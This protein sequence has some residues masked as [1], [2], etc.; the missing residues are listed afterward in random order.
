MTPSVAEITCMMLAN[1]AS[2]MQ[3]G[4]QRMGHIA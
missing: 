2:V 1:S 4:R 3:V